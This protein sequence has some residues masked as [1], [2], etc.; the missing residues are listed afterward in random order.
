MVHDLRIATLVENTAGEP[1]LL[2][3]HG[4]AFWIEA[5]GLRILFDTGQGKVLRHNAA[6]LSIPVDAADAIVLS[7]GHFDHTGG[8]AEVLG[9][10]RDVSLYLHPAALGPKYARRS[11]TPHRAIG[12]PESAATAVASRGDRVVW[13]RGPTELRPGILLTGEVPRRTDFE[14][15][16]G[17]FFCDAECEAPDPLMD[18][19]ALSIH[20]SSGPVVVLGCAHSGVV[21]TLDYVAELTGESRVRAVLGGMHLVRADA[22]RLDATVAALERYEVALLGPA[23]C[24][25]GRAAFRLRK[26]FP[27]GCVKCAAGSTFHFGGEA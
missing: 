14:D 5:D 4:L 25:G 10:R 19:Q 9:V 17:P 7:H 24:T 26:R 1:A 8:L 22:R 27:E 3:E 12:M 13:T 2:G 18:D 20:T 11:Q 6:R 15:V 23:H 16:G 21:N